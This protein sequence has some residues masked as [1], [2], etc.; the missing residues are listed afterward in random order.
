MLIN[1]KSVYSSILRMAFIAVAALA[2]SAA[3]NMSAQAQVNRYPGDHRDN[4]NHDGFN[5]RDNRDRDGGFRDGGFRDGYIPGT[6]L[7][8]N[9]GYNVK[10]IK[11]SPAAYGALSRYLN[12]DWDRKYMYWAPSGFNKQNMRPLVIS[13]YGN[14]E[15]VADAFARWYHTI[16]QYNYAFAAPAWKSG[17]KAMTPEEISAFIDGV[18]TDLQ[19]KE[20]INVDPAR[21]ILHGYER[22]ANMAGY[23]GYYNPG[24][25]MMVVVDSGPYPE[26]SG[27]AGGGTAN[28][29]K[30]LTIPADEL[31]KLAGS[32]I[33]L[34]SRYEDLAIYQKLEESKQALLAAGAKADLNYTK[35]LLPGEFSKSL[36][37]SIVGMFDRAIAGK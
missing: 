16:Y 36:S 27:A 11:D 8:K 2:I 23:L 20:G 34:Y 19:T 15:G 29:S 35:G 4:D 10:N 3:V 37:N 7:F 13:L 17:D 31:K 24:K 14:D 1:K 22:G 28:T 9:S 21:V 33:Y 26:I 12:G 6:R 5:N 18:I 32:Y 30:A 25:Y